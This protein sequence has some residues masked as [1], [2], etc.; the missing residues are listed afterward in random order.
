MTLLD[1]KIKK[2]RELF[3]GAEPSE[4]HLQRFEQKL[5]TLNPAAAPRRSFF[6][7]KLS[8]IAAVIIVLMGIST[9]LYFLNPNQNAVNVNGNEL[10]QELQEVKMYYNQVANKKLQ[11]IGNSQLTPGEAADV[12]QMAEQQINELDSNSAHLEKEL[13]NDQNNDKLKNAL[14][15]NYKTK[16]DL[17]DDILRRLKNI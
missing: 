4:G 5:V 14:I 15:V 13:K 17:L 1:D 8:K 10:P 3:D 12:R 9:A 7:Y 16:A 2:N 11:E 6:S